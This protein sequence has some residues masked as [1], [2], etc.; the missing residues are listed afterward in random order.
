[1]YCAARRSAPSRGSDFTAFAKPV[2]AAS[3]SSARNCST[4]C[5]AGPCSKNGVNQPR[6]N[7]T[8]LPVTARGRARGGGRVLIRIVIAR[9]RGRGRHG[10]QQADG[11]GNQ[12]GAKQHQLTKTTNR[13]R[14]LQKTLP[15][16]ATFFISG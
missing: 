1:M 5:R 9:A 7:G 14:H 11:T 12:A 13:W 4:A 16:A 8:G 10:E 15:G 6:S 2:S 3:Q